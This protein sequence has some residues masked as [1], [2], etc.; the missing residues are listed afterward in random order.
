MSPPRAADPNDVA[1]WVNGIPIG[2]EEFLFAV[3]GDFQQATTDAYNNKRCL[4]VTI[5]LERSD[6]DDPV[7]QY[8]GAG[9]ISVEIGNWGTKG[10]QS[11]GP[12]PSHESLVER[13]ANSDTFKPIA[14][15]IRAALNER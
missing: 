5:S 3:P 12:G 6:S 4:G 9:Y 1:P 11:C 14:G 2:C 15:I 13:V 8:I 10:G 7:A